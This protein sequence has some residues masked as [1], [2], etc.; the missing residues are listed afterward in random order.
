MTSH[1][2]RPLDPTAPRAESLPSAA[3]LWRGA[4][5][6]WGL[7]VPALREIARDAAGL[8]PDPGRDACV[9]A[10]LRWLERSQDRS[11][12]AD[13]GLARHYS[14]VSGWGPSYPETTGY[15]IPTLIDAAERTGRPDLRDRAARMVAWLESIQLASGAFQAG[16]AAASALVPTTF[17]TGQILIGLATAV[18][19]FGDR[20]A[21]A[22]NA[23]ARW[24]VETQD[25]DGA[26]RHYP[27]P[28]AI[29][30]EK[31]YET[32]VAWGLFLAAEVGERG[33]AEAAMLNVRWAISRMQSNGWMPDCCLN[34]PV[35]PLTH[36]LG[37]ALRGIV[38]AYRAS[39]DSDI[40]AAAQRLA[41]GLLSAQRADG[42]LPGRLDA[43]WGA[44]APW[45]CLTGNVQ[46][47]ACWLL[48]HA[49]TADP[50]YRDAASRAIG[51]VRRT[52]RPSGANADTAGGIKGAFPVWGAY[53]RFEFLNWAPKFYLDAQFL[54]EDSGARP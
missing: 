16:T 25:H 36:T 29:P 26:W 50:R 4:R 42:A 21:A 53:G 31:T 11:A 39:G 8:G 5:E 54:E 35:H 22:M 30:G 38:E 32:H 18:R 40:L 19:E 14:L 3:T 24:L 48:I 37:Y 33:W 15:V 46:I 13:G 12:S 10:A 52:M 45:S 51:F 9:D 41:D 20:H 17:N 1:A 28:Y 44:A 6:R 7:T 2:E 34:D 27:T 47:A 49:A 23:A 43:S